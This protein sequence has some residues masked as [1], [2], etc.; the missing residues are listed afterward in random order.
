MSKTIVVTLVCLLL[1]LPLSSSSSSSSSSPS[2]SSIPVINVRDLRGGGGSPSSPLPDLHGLLLDSGGIL[3]ISTASSS[4]S[5]SPRRDDDD[6]D[7]VVD[8]AALRTRALGGMCGC[9]ALNDDDDSFANSH[10]KDLRRIVLPDGAERRT[11]A[12][13]TIG[14][15][16]GGGGEEE[17]EGGGGTLGLPS[18]VDDACGGDAGLRDSLEDLRDAVSGVVDLFV[19]KLDAE[20]GKGEEEEARREGGGKRSR[21]GGRRYRRMLEGANHLEHFHVYSKGGEGPSSSKNHPDV[22]VDVDDGGGGVASLDYHTDAGFFLA[23]VPALDCTSMTSDVSSFFLRDFDGPVS[24][25]DDEVIVMMG[26]GAQYWLDDDDLHDDGR[27][28]VAASHALRLGRGSRRAWYGKMHLLPASLQGGG[29][30]ASSSSPFRL[31]DYDAHVPSSPLDGCGTRIEDA[32]NPSAISGRQRRQSSISSSSSNSSSRRRLQH[33][34]SPANCNNVT[35]FFCWYQCVGIP[36][37]ADAEGYVQDGYSLYCLDPALLPGGDAVSVSEATEPCRGGYVHNSH[38]VGSWQKTDED[39]PGYKLPYETREEGEAEEEIGRLATH[40]EGE[41]CYGGT[42]MYMDGFTWRGSTCVIY[43]FR[44]WVLSTPLKFA[45]AAFGSIALGVSLEYVLRARRGVYALP[46]GM[47]RLV[48][49][50]AFYGLQLTMGYFI[51]LVI[52]TYSGPLF[53]STVGGMMIGHVLFNAQDALTT[54][55]T[56]EKGNGDHG[57]RSYGAEDVP[58]ASASLGG[59]GRTGGAAHTELGSYQNGRNTFDC[60]GNPPETDLENS[61]SDTS[62]TEST[63]LRSGIAD[64]ATPCCQY[65]L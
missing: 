64:G 54:R 63:K 23:F 7:D 51:M 32:I 15:P 65:T 9:R 22:D 3:R 53:V 58:E 12:T 39:V 19:A 25:G 4:S 24:F 8:L 38:C 45:L 26:A 47:R 33:V 57:G 29:G 43:L 61:L 21:G 62:T 1:S 13:A 40:S 49:S 59:G 30:G 27:R 16:S 2:P 5:S 6:D 20:A 56:K 46:P 31:E 50:T 35:N 36:D 41:Y 17:E 48:L 44:S 18:W 28:F 14:F 52:M 42:S 60:C 10:P 34:N 37:A 11:L 55:W